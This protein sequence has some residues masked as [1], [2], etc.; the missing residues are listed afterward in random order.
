MLDTNI[1]LNLNERVLKKFSARDISCDHVKHLANI[2]KKIQILKRE[3]ETEQCER[4]SLVNRVAVLKQQDG[5][6]KG[7][8]GAIITKL[9]ELKKSINQKQ[10]L[11][12]SLSEDF[13]RQWIVIPNLPLDD[14]IPVG[15]E[16][17]N[18]VIRKWGKQRS[19]DF[20]PLNHWI[21]LEK[22]NLV[23]FKRAVK[24][25]SARFVLY[26]NK[27][28]KL[29]RALQNFTL[30]INEKNGYTEILPPVLVNWKSFY[31]SGQFP[32]FEKEVFSISDS[33]L[34]LSSTG[35]VQLVNF[36]R[37]EILDEKQLPIAFTTSTINFRS[38]AGN[39]GKDTKGIIRLHQFYK[40]ELVKFCKVENGV[41]E[42]EKTVLNAC[43][44]LEKL[45]LPY[46]QVL[47]ASKDMSVSSQKTYDLEVWMPGSGKYREISSISLC[48][49]YQSRRAM[50]RYNSGTVGDNRYVSTINGSSLALDRLFAAI[51]ENYQTADGNFE[52]PSVLE[53]YM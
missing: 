28:A 20:K 13:K 26:K 21:I 45:N 43:E 10:S 22:R 23:D 32:K 40:T 11:I 15:D 37:D 38:E 19:F 47:L 18:Q 49:T 8:N 44:I 30:D 4:N 42:H 34:F 53:R 17:M 27:G 52:V 9:G 6:I 25:A 3:V 12:V 50:I 51:V 36:F 1:L 5:V 39:A 35:E 46:Q 48:G 2:Y 33:D 31:G 24:L 16:S 14:E 7:D 41:D 29:M